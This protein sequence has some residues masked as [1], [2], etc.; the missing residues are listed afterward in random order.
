MAQTLTETE[1]DIEI[2]INIEIQ[3]FLHFKNAVV[4]LLVCK[5]K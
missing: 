5:S 4:Y 2:L 3:I 1:Y